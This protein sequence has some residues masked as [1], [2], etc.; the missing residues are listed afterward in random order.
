MLKRDIKDRYV[1]NYNPEMLYAWNANMDIQLALDPYA[2]ITYIVNYVNKDETGMT[3]FM[4]EALRTKAT[5][6]AN[7]KLNILKAA[8]FTNR[9]VGTSEAVYRVLPGMRLRDSN[10]SCI[11]VSS[12]FPENRSVFYQKVADGKDEEILNSINDNEDEE[13]EDPSAANEDE[14]NAHGGGEEV[15]IEGRAG[16]FVQAT[17][18]I[19]RYGARPD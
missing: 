18:M 3:K 1:N 15:E 19:D 16:K 9:Q 13:D 5:A 11:F 10:I 12:G 2:V 6:D 4:A 7:E 8:Y 14:Q 17:T